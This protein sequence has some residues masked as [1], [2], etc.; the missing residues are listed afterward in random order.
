[1]RTPYPTLLDPENIIQYL[2]FSYFVYD[3]GKAMNITELID[4]KTG[5]RK[6][7]NR[8]E[9]AAFKEAAKHMRPDMK[10]YCLMMYYTGCRLG[11]ALEVTPD[12]LDYAERRVVLRTLKQGKGKIRFRAVELPEDYLTA[13][14]DVYRAKDLQG[15]KAGSKPIWN[16]TDRTAKN[17]V[18]AVMKAAGIEG[19]KAS[20]R[21]LRHSMGVML[22]LDKTPANVIQDIL[23]HKAIKN[24]MIYLQV[25]GDDRRSMI[26]NVW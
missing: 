19:R 5:E 20:S 10:F 14:Q 7:L 13:L 9:R 8:D 4:T 22:A 26:S 1:M 25:V 17:Y 11:E 23:G 12:R 24:T 16:F 2:Y 3:K 21:G 18:S 15:K 6:Y